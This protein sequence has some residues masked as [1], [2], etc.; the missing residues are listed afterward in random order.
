MELLITKSEASLM[1]AQCKMIDFVN[2]SNGNVK[3][4][5][6]ES[7]GNGKWGMARLWRSWMSV[8][9]DFMAN[10]GVTMPLMTKSDGT[11]YGTRRFRGNDAHELFTAQWLGLNEKGERLS[12]RMSEGDNVADKG[13]R[14]V[15]MMR[16][17]Q[18]CIEKGIS[19]PK[20]RN[21][22]FNELEE[23]QNS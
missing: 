12:W 10:N 13:Q 23:A 5:L 22:E 17:Q 16:H 3:L 14:F 4:V 21:S 20:P 2:E 8:T 19:L 7:N 11:T 15:A 1:E 6:T 9:A 18:W